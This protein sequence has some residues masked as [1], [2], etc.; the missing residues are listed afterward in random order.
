MSQSVR[1]FCLFT[2]SF[3]SGGRFCSAACSILTLPLTAPIFP[4]P[5]EPSRHHSRVFIDFF[6]LPKILSAVSH[7]L[8]GSRTYLQK[9]ISSHRK[10]HQ[11]CLRRILFFH[12]SCSSIFP[13]WRKSGTGLSTG[14]CSWGEIPLPQTAFESWQGSLSR[15]SKHLCSVS[16]ALDMIASLSIHYFDSASCPTNAV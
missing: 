1:W 7:F 4:L 15:N 3:G 13:C 5:F 16:R 2:G 11:W 14:E 9:H 6:L 12:C 10:L 8:A